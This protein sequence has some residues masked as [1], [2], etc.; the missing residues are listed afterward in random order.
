MVDPNRGVDPTIAAKF[1]GIAVAWVSGQPYMLLPLT[2]TDSDHPNAA[3]GGGVA[4]GSGASFAII[5]YFLKKSVEDAVRS[6]TNPQ[7]GHLHESILKVRCAIA[8]PNRA[9]QHRLSGGQWPTLT[10]AQVRRALCRRSCCISPFPRTA[11]LLLCSVVLLTPPVI[12]PPPMG[13]APL[14]V[15]RCARL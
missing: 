2:G 7:C 8:S 4:E 15:L 1:E 13:G 6:P 10:P 5:V 14:C 9:A 3:P 12:R 11:L